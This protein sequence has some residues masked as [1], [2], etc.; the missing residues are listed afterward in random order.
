[1]AVALAEEWDSQHESI[2]LKTLHLNNF[3][4]KCIRAANDDGLQRY[5]REELY[6]ILENDQICYRESES[7]ENSYKSGLAK[8]QKEQTQRIFD[9][10]EKHYGVHLNVFHDIA[11]G[12]QHSSVCRVKPIIDT[13]DDYVL[14]SL[15]TVAQQSK[16]TSIALAFLLRND[17]SIKEAV[18]IARVDEN[19]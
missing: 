8:A 1:M 12:P 14:F 2:D 18:D 4:A 10:M 17:I 7:A 16:S 9:I 19:Y 5:M 6:T 13:V 11:S 3:L 15:Y